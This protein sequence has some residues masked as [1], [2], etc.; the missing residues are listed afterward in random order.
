MS[1]SREF[2]R[3]NDQWVR[4]GVSP[5]EFTISLLPDTQIYSLQENGIFQEQTEWLVNNTEEQDIE[6]VLHLGDIVHNPDEEYQW[7]VAEE[8]ISVLDDND[9]PSLLCLGNHDAVDLRNPSRFR[10]RFPFSRYDEMVE[11]HESLKESGSYEGYAENAYLTQ[12]VAGEQY[13]YLTLEF[14]SRDAVLDWANGVVADHPDHHVVV[15][16]H[17]YM[18]PEGEL[19]DSSTSYAPTGYFDDSSDR[20]NGVDVWEKFVSNHENILFVN[21]AHHL[22]TNAAD[23]VDSGKENNIVANMFSNYQTDPNGGDGWLRLHRMNMAEQR[24][25]VRTYSPFLNEWATSDREKFEF[26]LNEYETGL[27][28]RG[29]DT[30]ATPDSDE[31]RSQIRSIVR[32]ELADTVDN[33]YFLDVP[34]TEGSGETVS[35]RS[36]FMNQGELT[37]DNS[38]VEDSQGTAVSFPA[39]GTGAV[40]FGSQT[41][42]AGLTGV[43]WEGVVRP[44]SYPD[45]SGIVAAKHDGGTDG[46]WYMAIRD[47]ALKF[48][49]ISPTNDRNNFVQSYDFATG[50]VY[51]VVVTHD[52]ST[53]TFAQYV[54]GEQVATFEGPTDT[55]ATGKPLL[56]GNYTPVVSNWQ[57]EGHVYSFRIHDG[58]L[59]QSDI[60]DRYQ[61]LV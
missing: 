25:S 8:A 59:E 41:A 24:A 36:E 53:G 30:D 5:S 39:S 16:T 28:I 17:S 23:R 27:I 15:V 29:L 9:V 6:M 34:L 51:H 48:T 19:V 52:E 1:I 50:E 32:Q 61:E 12:E 43:T 54:N 33:E 46:E 55:K 10:D 57:F 13:L 56:I 20:N 18:G 58:K 21:S 26:D 2:V 3:R 49:H 44:S 47:D 7:D 22:A 37:G 31:L 42:H 14:G 60:E 45:S 40:N 11:N 35:D 4:D 38:W